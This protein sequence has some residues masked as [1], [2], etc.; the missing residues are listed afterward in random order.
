MN[1]KIIIFDASTLISFAINGLF[2]EIRELK[3]I[4]NGKFIVTQEIKQEAIE[5]PLK[6]RRFQLEALKIKELLDEKF[7]EMPES[8]GIKSSEISAKTQEFLDLSNSAF[9]G[10]GKPLHL[11]DLGEASCLALS[12]IANKKG[13]RNVLAIDER[14]M[15]MLIE[16]PDNLK[17]LLQRRTHANIKI[18]YNKLES[19]KNFKIIRSTELAYIAYKRK[20]IHIK[21]E[22]VL[23]AVL[24]GLKFNG[25]SI[26]DEEIAQ[27]KAMAR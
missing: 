6:V 22:D 7:L 10:D 12:V 24:Y 9:I 27:M 15:R 26:T 3:S 18:E 19:F 20:I 8:I 14:T 16:K 5:S 13:I 1:Q 21:G 23:G 11:I 17:E 25:A 2:E 4:F